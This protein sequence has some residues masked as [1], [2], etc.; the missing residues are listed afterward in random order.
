M[1]LEGSHILPASS[2]TIWTLLMDP[3][4]LA[5]VTPGITD[6]EPTGDDTF[7]AISKVKI[8]PVNGAFSGTVQI[9]DKVEGESFGLKIK[10]KSKIGNVSAEG[11]IQLIPQTPKETEVKFEGDAKLSGTLARTGQRVVS[12]VARTLTNQ[13]FKDLEAEIEVINI[14]EPETSTASDNLWSRFMNWL[15]NIF[16]AKSS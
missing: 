14:E 1:H 5:K 16:G 10:Q 6:L 2:S 12:G 15:K 8:G 11:A 13:F 4:I 9:V 7:K 3:E